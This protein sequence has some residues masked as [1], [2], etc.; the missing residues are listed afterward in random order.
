MLPELTQDLIYT[1]L[2]LI[3]RCTNHAMV[4]LSHR[5]GKLTEIVELVDR[6]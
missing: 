4:N 2:L 6:M 5:P 3:Y 1:D